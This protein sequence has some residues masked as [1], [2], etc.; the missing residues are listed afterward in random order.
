MPDVGQVAFTLERFE[1]TAPDRLEV[2]G[3]WEGLKGRRMAHPFLLVEIEG[4]RRRLPALPGGQLTA[5]GWRAAF[6]WDGE[7][8]ELQ[9]AELHVGRNLVVELPAPRR[10]RSRP[11]REAAQPRP[12][13]P[14]IAEPEVPEADAERLRAELEESAA[15]RRTLLDEAAALRLELGTIRSRLDELEE[16][17][18]GMAAR[19]AEHEGAL[20]ARERDVAQA[21]EARD[22]AVAEVAAARQA[23]AELRADGERR[24]VQARDALAEARAD[25]DHREEQARE[26]ATAD[27]EQRLAEERRAAAEV[28]DKLATARAETQRALDAEAAESERLRA[29]LTQAREEAEQALAGERAEI[30]R[31][32]EE[33]ADRTSERGDGAEAGA[34][35]RMQERVARELERERATVRDL[36]QEL[37]ETRAQTAEHRRAASAAATGTAHLPPAEGQGT[38]QGARKLHGWGSRREAPVAPERR[39]GAARAAAANRVPE[40]RPSQAAIWSVRALALGLVAVLLIALLM[41]VSRVM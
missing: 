20:A 37:E 4:R 22:A 40:P 6:A 19:L 35:R 26:A 1:W 17:R 15:A 32:R 33:L 25:A 38:S 23:V 11:R 18:D 3:K 5:D 36:R 31:L 2:V 21:I 12:T 27:V 28:R 39:A 16:E 10:R 7:P 24:D 30:A 9:A 14:P 34:A 41:I 8:V 29:S 13:A